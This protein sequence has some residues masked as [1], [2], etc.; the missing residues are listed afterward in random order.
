MSDSPGHS[1]GSFCWHEIGTRDRA[2]AKAFYSGVLAWQLEDVPMGPNPEDLYTMIRNSGGD[3]AGLYEMNGPQFENVPSHWMTYVWVDDVAAAVEKA[4]SL[5]GSVVV[6]PMDMPNIGSMAVLADPTGAH[7]AVFHGTG[8][9]GAAKQGPVAGAV[10]WN[11][12]MTSDVSKAQAFYGAMFG[13]G[14]NVQPMP[15]G[16]YAM[17]RQGEDNIA[18]MMGMDGPEWEGIPPHWMT[19]VVVDDVD[20]AAAKAATMGGAIRVPPMDIPQVGRFAVLADPSGA[21][22]SI[23]KFVEM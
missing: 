9:Q 3:V 6:D 22:F 21:V 1:H 14:V 16:D 15:T 12:L 8:H 19:Y 5:G 18:G 13:W 11:E 7:V 23:I 4:K 2:A 17:F 20:A 10:G